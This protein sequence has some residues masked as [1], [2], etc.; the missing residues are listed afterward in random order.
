MGAVCHL[1]DSIL[2]NNCDV[3][4]VALRGRVQPH[5][6]AVGEPRTHLFIYGDPIFAK[7]QVCTGAANRISVRSSRGEVMSVRKCCCC[8]VSAILCAPLG[9]ARTAAE[10][11]AAEEEGRKVAGMCVHSRASIVGA[12]P[13]LVPSSRPT[14]ATPRQ[15]SIFVCGGGSASVCVELQVGSSKGAGRAIARASEAAAAGGVC[16]PCRRHEVRGLQLDR[17]GVG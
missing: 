9:N 14:T 6:V 15:R 10:A 7:D 5:P 1:E 13:R 16:R 3:P 8:H 2:P 4:Q 12:P 17:S 11:A